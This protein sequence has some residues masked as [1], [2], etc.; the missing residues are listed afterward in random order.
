[1]FRLLY[2]LF[3]RIYTLGIRIA[4]L[5]DTKAKNW[6]DGR[7]GWKEKLAVKRKLF[8]SEQFVWFH[9][10]SLGEFEQGRPL[11]EAF[12]E[13]Y[14]SKK[15][16]LTFFSPSGYEIRKNYPGADVIGYLPQDTLQNAR[17]WLDLF[18]PEAVFF[19]KYEYWFN[20]LYELSRRKIPVFMVSAIFREDQHFFRGY[21]GWFRKHLMNIRYFFVQNEESLKFLKSIGI[22]NAEITGDTRFDRV[23]GIALLAKRFPE[24][25]MFVKEEKIILAG[26]SWPEDEAILLDYYRNSDSSIK[27]IIAPHEVDDR[28][29]TNIR[30]A[31]EDSV[32]FSELKANTGTVSARVLIIDGIGYLSSLYQY[33]T[34]AYIGGGFGAGIHNILEAATFGKP[35]VF[36]PKYSKFQEARDLITEGGAFPVN[37]SEELKNILDQLLN[38]PAKYETASAICRNYVERKRGATR[39]IMN[40]IEQI[41]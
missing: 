32:A 6:I 3:V 22:E 25:E 34:V 28:H 18:R 11:I 16:L 30:S 24:V 5:F 41:I 10:A 40:R 9:C 20:Y 35:V 1:M 13:K 7:R 2:T 27:F 38:D 8:D 14:P 15:I 36:G 29:I 19:I 12:R 17:K 31:F 39:I 37:D 33:A 26:S 4:S 23:Y 21:G